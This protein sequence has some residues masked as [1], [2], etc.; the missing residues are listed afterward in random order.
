ML[1]LYQQLVFLLY[2]IYDVQTIPTSLTLGFL[3]PT[4]LPNSNT[5]A[6][7]HPALFAFK[8]AIRDINNRSDLL[9]RTKLNFVS[10]NTNSDI[11]DGTIVAFWQCVYG[12]VVGIV[13]EYVSVVSQVKSYCTCQIIFLSSNHTN[14]VHSICESLLQSPSDFV[15]FNIIRIYRVSCKS[16]SLFFTH[17]TKSKFGIR[18]VGT[19]NSKPRLEKYRVNLYH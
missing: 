3:G 10:N 2:T 15:R 12:N 8:L 6:G 7:G 19:F 18:T 11:G 13:G 4:N 1:L 14:L 17:N 5:Q 16:L 9:P